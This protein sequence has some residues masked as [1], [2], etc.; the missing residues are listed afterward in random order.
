MSKRYLTREELLSVQFSMLKE[1]HQACVDNGLTYYLAYG[2]LI[3][4]VRHKGF[5]PWD[6]DVD[7]MMPVED[8]E[9]L[10]T[11]Y[12]SDRY[13]ITDCFH[14]ARHKL[15]FPRIYDSF[16]CLDENE[17]SL[18]VCIDIYMMHGAPKNQLER[19]KHALTITRLNNAKNRYGKYFG[20]MTR[21][22]FPRLWRN[23]H[24]K[25]VSWYCKKIYKVL[26][27][28]KSNS[29]KLI[30]AYSGEGL[31]DIFWKEYFDSTVLLPFNGSEFYAPEKY[32]E[33]LSTTYGDYMKLPPEEDR[34]PYHGASFYCWKSNAIKNENW[35]KF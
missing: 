17:S 26:S 20:M 10:R 2:T 31:T 27:R 34:H 23:Y 22:F 7:I 11:I 35:N 3:G 1:I 21:H 18:G 15:C 30:Y 32:H 12:K 14:D 28:Y 4:A 29:S 33:V 8:Y 13:Y 25:V 19:A 5:I 6:D 9:K 16:T 24:S